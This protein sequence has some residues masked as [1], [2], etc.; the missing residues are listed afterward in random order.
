MSSVESQFWTSHGVDVSSGA[1]ALSEAGYT[2][3]PPRSGQ[4]KTVNTTSSE[5][6]RMLSFFLACPPFRG[7]NCN[8]SVDIE[9]K[10]TEV[11]LRICYNFREAA[12]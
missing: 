8:G 3:G 10:S 5:G 11:L 4:P 7:Q 9:H 1:G 2:D 12:T 6:S